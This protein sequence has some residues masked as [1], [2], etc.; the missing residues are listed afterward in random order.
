MSEILEFTVTLADEPFDLEYTLESGQVFRWENTGEWW[1]GH[2]GGGILRLKQQGN[3]LECVSSSETLDT[4]FARNYFRLEENL[5]EILPSI[6]KD[7]VITNAIQRFYGLRLL[8]QERWECLISFLLATNSNIPRIRRMITNVCNRFG[9]G[10][11][12]GGAEYRTFP[13]PEA[14]AE[15]TVTELV[16][17]GLGYRAEF[18]KRVARAVNDGKLELSELAIL[19]YE[20]AR[21]LMLKE[22]LGG[23]LLPGVGPKVA[24][25]VL[26]FSCDKDEAFPIDVWI[27]RALARYYPNLVRS[28]DRKKILSKAT[29]SLSGK[30]Y[31][32]VSASARSYFGRHA[33]Y[34]QQ[35][36]YM[37]AR[38]DDSSQ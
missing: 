32:S 38:I 26:L 16:E 5:K 14:L 19:D 13:T 9:G 7:E 3:S 29:R 30:L 24:D 25:C 20:Q 8:R 28:K 33:G 11:S 36:L 12:Y 35:Y 15:A 21:E 27:G 2:V 10:L 31:D 4:A 6:R 34:A 23:K 22:L 37:Y 17:C 18:V 1:V